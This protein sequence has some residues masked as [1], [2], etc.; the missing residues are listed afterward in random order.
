MELYKLGKTIENQV[1]DIQLALQQLNEARDALKSSLKKTKEI[2]IAENDTHQKEID[3]SNLFT[4][5]NQSEFDVAIADLMERNRAQEEEIKNL[6]LEQESQAILVCEVTEQKKK[7]MED[8]TLLEEDK[9]ILTHRLEE[10]SEELSKISNQQLDTLSG[11]MNLHHEL[12]I[13]EIQLSNLKLQNEQLQNELKRE[14]EFVD[15]FNKP[16]EVIKYF[17]QLLKS[18]KKEIQQDQAT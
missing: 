14:K 12:N 3:T 15:S 7:A 10:K 5:G 2:A 1:I 17:E 18:M 4:D 9:R 8:K 11:M 13:K 16:S 6:K